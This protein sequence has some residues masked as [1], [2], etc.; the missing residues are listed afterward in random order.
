[1]LLHSLVLAAL[2]VSPLLPCEA[3]A[4]VPLGPEFQV[5]SY[6]TNNQWFPS[7]AADDDGNFVVVW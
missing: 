7:V 4:L 3:L 1:M 6:T 2:A 5:N